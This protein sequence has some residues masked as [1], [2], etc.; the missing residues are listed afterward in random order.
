MPVGSSCTNVTRARK[1]CDIRV[2]GKS[3]P[4]LS[5]NNP[6][7]RTHVFTTHKAVINFIGEVAAG[8]CDFT[9]LNYSEQSSTWYATVVCEPD[10]TEHTPTKTSLDDAEEKEVGDSVTRSFITKR[11]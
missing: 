9:G 5:P 8:P 6:M 4:F 2:L 7:E 11:S 3:T 10:C 1:F